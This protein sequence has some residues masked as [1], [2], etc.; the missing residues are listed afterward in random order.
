M[1]DVRVL[2]CTV[3]PDKADDVA[4]A[5][6]DRRLVACVNILPGARS[7]Y[8]WKGALEEASESLLVLKTVADKV[9]ALTEAIHEVHPYDVPELLSLPV[10]GGSPA[11]LDWLRGELE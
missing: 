5:L 6:L 3:P 11:Y 4:R 7:L 8:R 10:E 9:N 2:L 1:S